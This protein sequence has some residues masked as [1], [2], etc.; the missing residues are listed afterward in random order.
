MIDGQPQAL[1]R[2]YGLAV[3][4]V[5]SENGIESTVTGRRAVLHDLLRSLQRLAAAQAHLGGGEVAGLLAFSIRKNFLPLFF[6]VLVAALPPLQPLRNRLC[7]RDLLAGGG[8]L[9]LRVLVMLDL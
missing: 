8:R 7:Q 9:S 5:V 1:R 3:A 2:L 4:G 6:D